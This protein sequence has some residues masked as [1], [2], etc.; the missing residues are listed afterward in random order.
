MNSTLSA[1]SSGDSLTAERLPPSGKAPSSR[2]KTR[3]RSAEM[4]QE[5]RCTTGARLS[6]APDVAGSVLPRIA[7]RTP[8][9]IDPARCQERGRSSDL[10][11][12][13][14]Q[15]D[16]QNL[17][18]L[19]WRLSTGPAVREVDPFGAWRRSFVA[20]DDFDG[21]FPRRGERGGSYRVRPEHPRAG[22]DRG[23]AGTTRAAELLVGAGACVLAAIGLGVAAVVVSRGAARD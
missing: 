5:K 16:D 20:C 14:I 21:D 7:C 3:C 6:R 23:R 13:L 1:C 11:D 18:G 17:R 15:H 12:D 22:P 8:A 4:R 9:P 2:V 19:Q 10:V